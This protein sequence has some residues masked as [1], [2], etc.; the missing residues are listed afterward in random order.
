MGA[1][2]TVLGSSHLSSVVAALWLGWG[3]SVD[4]V[5]LEADSP[6]L[7]GRLPVREPGLA[8]FLAEMRSAGRYRARLAGDGAA[9][10]AGAGPGVLHVAEDVRV[11][12][13]GSRD[14][15]QL[16]RLRAAIAALR[17]DGPSVPLVLVSSQVEVGTAAAWREELTGA[18]SRECDVVSWPENFQLGTAFDAA[19]EMREVVIGADSAA[20]VRRLRELVPA[21]TEL[22]VLGSTREAEF[23]KHSVNAL[24]STLMTFGNELAA[25]CRVLEISD[26][27][28]VAALRGERRFGPRMPILGG[29]PVTAPT[30]LREVATIAGLAPERPS[31]AADVLALNRLVVDEEIDRVL[32]AVGERS[33]L[34][35]GVGYKPEATFPHTSFGTR[36]LDACDMRDGVYAFHP[37]FEAHSAARW[38]NVTWVSDPEDLPAVDV[39]VEV[40]PELGSMIRARTNGAERLSVGVHGPPG[41]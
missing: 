2:I 6:L 3:R 37:G 36:L 16:Q 18:W 38:S 4:H 23:Y 33:M 41:R 14:H 39:V 19:R 29:P 5:V 31:L 26:E 24:L 9:P 17:P 20:A 30:L 22:R 25:L 21:E 32:A 28:I 12:P 8:E 34:V 35:A 7:E 10:A 40:L 11:D 15:R 1:R 13:D 27:R